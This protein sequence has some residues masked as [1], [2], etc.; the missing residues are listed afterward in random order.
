VM[1]ISWVHHQGARG[2]NRSHQHVFF[3]IGAV[4]A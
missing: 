1:G 4:F 3:F 2:W